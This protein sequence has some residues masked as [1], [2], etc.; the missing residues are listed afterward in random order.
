MKD[1]KNKLLI[2]KD[3]HIEK[4]DDEY[5]YIDV[6][7]KDTIMFY[8]MD[9]YKIHTY[10]IHKYCG[11][12]IEFRNIKKYNI[13]HCSRCNL[14]VEIPQYIKTITELKEYFDKKNGN[15]IKKFTRFEIME[16]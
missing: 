10:Q 16:I 1:I 5:F 6:S 12:N 2:Y 9:T 7:N 4:L 14:R 13:L 3:T 15:I 11:G 8:V